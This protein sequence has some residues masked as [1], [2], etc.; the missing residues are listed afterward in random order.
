MEE[1]NQ[2]GAG[3]AE[4]PEDS[5]NQKRKKKVMFWGIGLVAVAVAVGAVIYFLLPK[6]RDVAWFSNQ[7]IA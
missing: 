6:A 5:K 4:K 2:Q 3:T 1:Q 7:M